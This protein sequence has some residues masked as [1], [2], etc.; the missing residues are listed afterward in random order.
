[1]SN[2]NLFAL[3]YQV[4]LQQHSN[5]KPLSVYY[6]YTSNPQLPSRNDIELKE[7][8]VDAEK[9]DQSGGNRHKGKVCTNRTKFTLILS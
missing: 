5:F 4:L 7:K 8:R 6:L 1:M 2:W 3:I 9:D